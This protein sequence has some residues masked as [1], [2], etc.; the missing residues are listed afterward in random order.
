[1]TIRLDID[2]S[3]LPEELA[4]HAQAFYDIACSVA[5]AAYA[6]QHAKTEYDALVSQHDAWVRNP[7]W[8]VHYGLTDG[9]RI[10]NDLVDRII[11][12]Q[13]DVIAATQHAH[14]MQLQYDL[15]L[16]AQRGMEHRKTCLEMLCRFKL[17]AFND[18][19]GIKIKGKI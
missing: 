6:L 13:P 3:K 10:T 5:H 14:E 2:D 9:V 18:A 1:M 4:D 16:A 12:T 8:S 11:S 19:G 17:S 7:E 15:W